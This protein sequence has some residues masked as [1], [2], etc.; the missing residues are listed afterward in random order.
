MKRNVTNTPDYDLARRAAMARW[1]KQ[2]GDMSKV[3]KAERNLKAAQNAVDEAQLAV[4]RG[5][6]AKESLPELMRQLAEARAHV[7]I[8]ERNEAFDN[9]P[10]LKNEMREITA[11]LSK[12]YTTKGEKRVFQILAA[13]RMCGASGQS[14]ESARLATA[15]IKNEATRGGGFD[16]P[17]F[18]DWI[19]APQG[20]GVEHADA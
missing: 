5:A 18:V 10:K 14:Y 13:A 7:V 19:H 4:E 2:E 3:E 9:V 15:R 8:A 11:A 1:G 17:M 6:A 20:Q 12:N 16:W